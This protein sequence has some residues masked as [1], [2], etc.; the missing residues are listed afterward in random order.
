MTLKCAKCT[1]LGVLPTHRT[2]PTCLGSGRIERQV[3]PHAVARLLSQ[4]LREISL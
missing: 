1:G 3:T 2:C 4:Y